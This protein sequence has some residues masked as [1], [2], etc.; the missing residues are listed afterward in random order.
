MPKSKKDQA[1]IVI[2]LGGSLIVPDS[3]DTDFITKFKSIIDKEI[4]LG[5]RFII[6]CGG[7]RVARNYQTAGQKITKLRASDIDWL[8]IHSTRLNAHL[9]K[10]IFLPKVEEIVVHDPHEKITFKKSILVA[11]GWKP[12]WSTDYDAILLAKRFK[13]KK[14]INLSNIDYICDKDP[15]KHSDAKVLLNISWKDYRKLI[16]AKWSPGLNSPFD[17]IASKEAQ[18]NN[19]QVAVISGENLDQLDNFIYDKPFEGTLIY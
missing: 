13:A 11:A 17:P 3:I 5:K 7:G 18:K 19:I 12:G 15:K 10:T 2:S 4:A 1:P 8:G 14:V 9:I 6:I 16:P